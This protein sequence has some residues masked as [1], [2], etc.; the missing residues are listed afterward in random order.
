MLK[1]KTIALYLLLIL[2]VLLISNKQNNT[3]P[4]NKK[5]MPETDIE[6]G[7]ILFTDPILSSDQTVSCASC[8][9]PENA[10]ADD[11]AQSMGVN[12]SPTPRNTP[13]ATYMS[14]RV[15]FFWDGRASSLEQQ[16]LGPITGAGEMNLPIKEAVKRL[17][18]SEYYQAAF[19][20][21]YNTPPDS[22]TMVKAI[23]SFERTLETYDSAYDRY[24]KGDENALSESA[25]RGLKLFSRENTCAASACH[26]GDDFSQDSLV[27]INVNAEKDLG[28]FGITKSKDDLGKFKVPHLRN[29]AITAPYMHDGS[30]KT[31]REVVEFYNDMN[32]FPQ[33]GNSHEAVKHQRTRPMTNEEIEDVVEFMKALTDAR[34]ESKF[35]KN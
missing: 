6:L 1:T 14:K 2:G 19:R 33:I 4:E 20:K 29:I 17:Q 31:L 32:N 28:R 3:I 34:Y 35:K 18:E 11:V 25:F 24:L 22:L 26:S 27:N 9:K 21:I 16:A 15:H 7:E 23:A 30:K 8:H 5:K 13:T 10:F 12:S